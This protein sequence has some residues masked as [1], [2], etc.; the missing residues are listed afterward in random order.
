MKNVMQFNPLPHDNSTNVRTNQPT[1]KINPNHDRFATDTSCLATLYRPLL[2][3]TFNPF[4]TRATSWKRQLK[5]KKE[6]KRLPGINIHI[7]SFSSDGW[8]LPSVGMY[9]CVCVWRWGKAGRNGSVKVKST[10]THLN[11]STSPAPV[12]CTLSNRETP[13][14]GR[15]SS[16][17]VRSESKDAR[18]WWQ[19]LRRERGTPVPCT[20]FDASAC[21]RTYTLY[22]SQGDGSPRVG[23]HSEAPKPAQ[24]RQ[25]VTSDN[26]R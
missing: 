4:L 23:Q 16:P 14:H 3:V 17:H 19:G 25:L 2:P 11:T 6:K 7:T 12:G 5:E 26:K 15:P 21:H 9:V 24:H 1:Q 8:H 10:L 22:A 13:T 18:S 20:I